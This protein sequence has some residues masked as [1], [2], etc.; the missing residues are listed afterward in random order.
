MRSAVQK[1]QATQ[2]PAFSGTE[3]NSKLVQHLQEAGVRPEVETY[4]EKEAERQ[5]RDY[6]AKAMKQEE[7]EKETADKPSFLET[8]MD[9]LTGSTGNYLQSDGRSADWGAATPSGAASGGDGALKQSLADQ[10]GKSGL[11]ADQA[12]KNPLTGVTTATLPAPQET[13][14]PEQSQIAQYFLP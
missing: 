6:A 8:T 10:T 12:K 9:I 4:Y 7:P 5:S 3:S 13:G 1:T 11:N 2:T 14:R